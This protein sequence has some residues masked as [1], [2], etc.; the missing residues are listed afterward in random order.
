ML[1]QQNKSAKFGV[2]ITLAGNCKEALTFYQSCFGGELFLEI[3]EMPLNPYSIKP[4]IS[5]SLISERIVLY[6]S[7][8]VHDEGYQM[9]NHL[10]IYFPCR[11]TSER[12]SLI[13]QLVGDIEDFPME[14]KKQRLI[15]I[16]DLFGVRWILGV[17]PE[18]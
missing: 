18:K 8:L 2:F 7:D 15:E 14:M 4:V 12:F 16:T 9:G 6:G 3:L 17:S 1:T 11:N 13:K 10:A 5:G